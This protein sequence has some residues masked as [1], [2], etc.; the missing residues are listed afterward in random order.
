MD[1]DVDPLLGAEAVDHAVVEVDELLE[2]VLVRPGV[3]RV[4]LVR[5]PALGEVD[6]DAHGARVEAPADVLLDLVAEVGEELVARIPRDLLLERVEQHQHRGRDHRLLD[7]VRRDRAVLGHELRRERLVA[8]R[9]AGQPRE[10]AVVAVV[11]DREELAVPREVVG[12]ARARQRVGDRVRREA[13]LALLPV[14][15]DRLAGRL[16]PLDRVRRGRVLLGLQLGPLDLSPGRR[17]RTPP[18]ASS[19]AAAS[20]P[21]RWECPCALLA[22]ETDLSLSSRKLSRPGGR[23]PRQRGG[24]EPRRRRLAARP[25]ADD[26]ADRIAID[27]GERDDVDV[28]GQPGGDRGE[29]LGRLRRR[30]HGERDAGHAAQLPRPRGEQRGIGDELVRE[31]DRDPRP[32]AL[33]R[34]GAGGQ[35]RGERIAERVARAA[36]ESGSAAA[37]RTSAARSS[38]ISNLCGSYVA[39]SPSAAS[40]RS[41]CSKY[42]Q[43][44][45][46]PRGVAAPAGI[47]RR[48]QR[49][50]VS[51][52]FSSRTR[53]G[54]ETPR[55]MLPPWKR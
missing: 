9:P 4:V 44:V 45:A 30:D 55:V 38:P 32:G 14:G 3:A 15:H 12:Q 7:R 33:E 42:V 10:L 51:A 40:S 23:E 1:A 49:T 28:V 24:A 27:A 13:R 53:A 16:Q 41:Q 31:R 46:R 8:E 6:R 19:A 54:P 21:T 25:L 50:N 35:S 52:L 17:P 5:Q 39:G 47:R 43:A 36:A 26:R 22:F 37:A 20:R 34:R 29:R 11:E 48:N 2:H 18:A